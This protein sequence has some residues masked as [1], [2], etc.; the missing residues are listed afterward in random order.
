MDSLRL[1]Q[2]G[3]ASKERVRSKLTDPSSWRLPKQPSSIAPPHV[4]TN[5]DQDPV[6]VEKQTWTSWV[7]ITYWYSDLVTISTW[8]SSSSILTTGL[9]ATD[10]LVICFVAGVCNAVPTVLNGAIGTDLHIPFPVAVR[11][12]YGYWLSYFCVVSRG[13]LA[14]FWFGIHSTAGGGCVKQML[15]AI[16]PSFARVSNTLP[17]WTGLNTQGMISYLIYWLIQL[18]LLLIPTH[19]L[20]YLFWIKTALVTPMALAMVIYMSVKAGG[21]GEFFY[22][23]ATVSGSARAWLWLSSLTSVTGAYST[24][25]VNIPDFSRFGKTHGAQVWQLPVIPILKVIV[26]AFGILSAS[27]AKKIYGVAYWNPLDIINEWQGTSGGRAAAF[28]CA[29]IWLLASA[30]VNVSANAISFANDITALAPKY[31][32]IRRGV[33]FASFVGGWA[34]CPWIIL[35]SATS[36]LNFMSAY[37]IFM[38]PMAGIICS[39]Y[40]LVKKR[41]YDVP[42]LYDPAGIYSYG[43]WRGCN[44]RALVSTLVTIVPLLPALA[45]KVTPQNIT[46][47]V[48]LQNLFSFNWLYG[49]FLSLVM[50]WVLNLLFPHNE[51]LITRSVSGYPIALDIEDV[52]ADVESHKP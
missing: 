27:A 52:E 41:R 16:W 30:S 15:K 12:S 18:P 14:L 26:G 36:F 42:G 4:W 33:I 13:I 3:A 20:Q 11:A 34:L 50:Y 48:G 25:A 29:A 23:P 37:A 39:D 24:L 47:P 8:G 21:S 9:T 38:A 46:I 1:G 6:P 17:T 43:R 35:A 22:A 5:A 7:F 31:F 19:K 2:R 28:F 51:T 45:K 32:N 49:F 44:W 10:A 40:W